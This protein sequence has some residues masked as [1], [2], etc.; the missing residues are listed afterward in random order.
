MAGE[1]RE[2][3]WYQDKRDPGYDRYWNG[4]DWTLRRERELPAPPVKRRFPI[5]LM[6]I[7]GLMVLRSVA[8]VVAT[9][10]GDSHTA[11]PTP[12]PSSSVSAPQH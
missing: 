11:V 12:T 9:F 1:A 8:G 6:V 10:E 7:A 4:R 5:W 3:G 2:P